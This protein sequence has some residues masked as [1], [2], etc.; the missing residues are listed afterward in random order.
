MNKTRR[1]GVG[2]IAKEIKIKMNSDC[3][4]RKGNEINQFPSIINLKTSI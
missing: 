3:L 4:Q 2:R 1:E